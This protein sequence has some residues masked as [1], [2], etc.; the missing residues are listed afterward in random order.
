LLLANSFAQYKANGKTVLVFAL[1][2]VFVLGFVSSQNVFISSG[3]IFLDYN[4]ALDSP[5]GFL[6]TAGLV[7]VFLLF[8]SFFISIIIFSVRRNLSKLKLHF[9]LHEMMQRFTLKIF[10]FYLLYCF[11]LFFLAVGLLY[12]NI[13]LIL[14]NFLLL[15]VSVA[16][17]FVP[18]SIVIDEEDLLHA[19][20]NNLEFILKNKRPVLTVLVFAT[21]LLAVLQVIEFA[22]DQIA[23]IGS[24]VSLFLSL[25]FILP[26]VEIMKTYLYM[27][28]FDLI[29]EHEIA[30]RKRPLQARPEPASIAAAP[31]P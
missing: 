25:V 30:Q 8:Y 6:L 21:L 4:I 10:I 19:V 31:K 11:L 12:L 17:L 23:L 3:S 2:L 22:I 26:F 16:L 24:L 7:A 29:K 15:L 18:Q 9:Y 13:S 20:S 5:T 1:L 28:R 27:M 14:I